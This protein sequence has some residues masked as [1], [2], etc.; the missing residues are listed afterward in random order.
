MSRR[1]EVQS[2]V[3]GERERVRVRTEARSNIRFL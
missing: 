2:G 1:V 3:V